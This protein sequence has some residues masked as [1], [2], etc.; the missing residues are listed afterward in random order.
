MTRKRGLTLGKFAPLPK[1]HQLVIETALA[2]MD[3]VV[4]LSLNIFGGHL[5][6]LI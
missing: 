6:T 1:G 2:E 5:I 4:V 3:E